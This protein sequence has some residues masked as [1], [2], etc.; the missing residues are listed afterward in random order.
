MSIDSNLVLLECILAGEFSGS[1][2]IQWSYN[3]QLLRDGD[4]YQ[5]FT[6]NNVD[7]TYGKCHRSQ[8]QIRQANAN[9]VGT[10]T[11]SFEDMSEDITVMNVTSKLY[12]IYNFFHFISPNLS[13]PIVKQFHSLPDQLVLPVFPKLL[14]VLQLLLVLNQTQLFQSLL[15]PHL[16]YYVL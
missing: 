11:C 16:Q 9:D 7:C 2:N 8:L 15:E 1:G 5:V 4:K 14:L 3:G 13:P 10:Y 6:A 12:Y